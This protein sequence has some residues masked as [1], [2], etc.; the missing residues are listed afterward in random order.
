MSTPVSDK[1][2]TVA[3]LKEAYDALTEE[4]FVVDITSG[5]WSGSGSDYYITV[6][7]SN[8]TANSILVVDYDKNSQQYLKGPVWAVPAAGSFT[9]HTSAVPTGTVKILVR[10]PGTMGE[11]NY[12]V[13]ADVY[14]KSQTYSKTEAVAKADIVNNLTNTDPT[15]VLAAPQGKALN[16]RITN[17]PNTI[18]SS[19]NVLIDT[20]Q[21]SQTET[22]YTLYGSRK[23]SDYSILYI[24]PM[25]EFY[26][27]PGCVIP[28]SSFAGSSNGT[29]FTCSS[30]GVE[31]EVVVK[32]ESDTQVRMKYNASSTRDVRIYLGALKLEY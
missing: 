22:V 11:A 18:Y 15:K 8:I 7:A 23:F 19:Y 24:T 14:S 31:V 30:G 21:I 6:N 32:F 20:V 12:H 26:F 25:V 28:R 3:G 9:I 27:R 1:L 16:D 13:L 29:S 5:Q 10:F 4:P 2:V 17:L